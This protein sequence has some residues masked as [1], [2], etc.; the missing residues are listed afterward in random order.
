MLSL[1]QQ[2]D[3]ISRHAAALNAQRAELVKLEQARQAKAAESRQKQWA[4]QK[5]KTGL[6][7]ALL[8]R[9]PAGPAN[10]ISVADIHRL[11]ADFPHAPTGISSALTVLCKTGD[12]K[13]TGERRA[14]RYYV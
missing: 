11:F 4:S 1:A 10:A 8:A 7:A 3:T 5:A 12:I 6:T 14:Y 9:L 2:L 13:R